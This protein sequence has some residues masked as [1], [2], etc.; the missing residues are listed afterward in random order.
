MEKDAF[1]EELIGI[2]EQDYVGIYS[3]AVRARC[4]WGLW[5]EAASERVPRMIDAATRER[6]GRAQ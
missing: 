2:V 6:G 4:G 5:P 3:N 1:I